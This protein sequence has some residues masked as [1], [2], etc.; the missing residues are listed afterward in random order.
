[1]SENRTDE[2]PVLCLF[3]IFAVSMLYSKKV[4]LLRIL[5]RNVL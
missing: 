2:S 4:A 3:G 5:A 1:M